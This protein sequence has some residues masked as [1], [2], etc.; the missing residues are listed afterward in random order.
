MYINT[1]PNGHEIRQVSPHTI[2][3]DILECTVIL[4][5]GQS[6]CPLSIQS[7]LIPFTLFHVILSALSF[8]GYSL[9]QRL[10]Q[11]V[12]VDCG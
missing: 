9:T 6:V 12:L 3:T 2:L 4:A 7:R 10:D 8:I 5:Y 11:E 1:G